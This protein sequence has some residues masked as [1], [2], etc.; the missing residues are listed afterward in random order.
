MRTKLIVGA[1]VVAAIFAGVFGWRSAPRAIAGDACAVSRGGPLVAVDGRALTDGHARAATVADPGGDYELRHVATRGDHVAY[2]R[3]RVGND[4]LVVASGGGLHVLAQP[5]EIMHPVWGDG[6]RLAWGLDDRLVIR[7]ADGG[8]RSIAGPRPGGQVISPAFDDGAI[9]A[10]VAAAPTPGAPEGGWSEDVWRLA[11]GRWQRLTTFP[12]DADR[13]TAVRTLMSA[14][15][16]SVEFVV[17]SGRSSATGM[18]RFA[19]WRL[20]GDRPQLVRELPEEMYLAGYTPTGERLWNVPD[21]ANERWLIR[22]DDGELA[23]C[24][25]VAVDPMDQVDPDRTGH[26]APPSKARGGHSEPGDPAEVALLVGDFASE[27]AAGVVADRVARA[28]AGSLPVDVL[29]GG[30]R[31]SVVQPGR[32]AVVVR[33]GADT[34]GVAELAHLRAMV[35]DLAAHAFIVVP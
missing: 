35:P 26:A 27:T 25:A 10:A 4:S 5:S 15:D 23:G 3:D 31:S 1:L 18:P 21:R 7:H 20:V 30:P 16:G 13:W 6:G 17:V 32:W 11:N 12:A 8:I 33:L 19:L 28:Y 14:P 34:D 9:V 24:G 29:R 22:T 2:V